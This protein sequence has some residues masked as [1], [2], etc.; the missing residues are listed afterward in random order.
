MRLEEADL[1]EFIMI[2]KREFKQNLFLDEAGAVGARVLT[3]YELLAETPRTS[4]ET[5]A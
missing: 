2:W 5:A 3:L 4:D 1:K